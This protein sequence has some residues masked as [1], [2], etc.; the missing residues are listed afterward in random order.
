MT[1]AKV[2]LESPT[3]APTRKV[4]AAG[5]SGAVTTILLFVLAQFG[6]TV[7]GEVGAAL[8]V[9]ISFIFSY[10]TTETQLVPVKTEVPTQLSDEVVDNL[11]VAGG[12][13]EG[14]RNSEV[15]GSVAG[16]DVRRETKVRRART[17]K[18]TRKSTSQK[19]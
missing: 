1:Y 13:N 9:V 19:R 18:K 5:I 17:S 7:D 11:L 4:A 14:T 6:I 2:T 8:A 3:S 16:E 10:F 15:Y 12:Q